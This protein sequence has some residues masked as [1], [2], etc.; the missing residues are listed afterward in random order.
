MIGEPSQ[1]V[2]SACGVSKLVRFPCARSTA[3]WNASL[4]GLAIKVSEDGPITMYK[5]GNL[6]GQ[7]A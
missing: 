1:T 7:M 3:A 6:V 5:S 4:Y 2:L